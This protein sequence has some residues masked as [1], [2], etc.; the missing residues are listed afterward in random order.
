MRYRVFIIA[1]LPVRALMLGLL[2]CAIFGTCKFVLAQNL[3]STNFCFFCAQ[4]V[5]VISYLQLNFIIIIITFVY[6][7]MYLIT[8]SVKLI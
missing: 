3:K 4:Q 6:S 8:K 7:L 5:F 2:Y 1:L